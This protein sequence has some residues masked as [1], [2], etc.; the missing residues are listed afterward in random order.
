MF[1]IELW[2]HVHMGEEKKVSSIIPGN[3]SLEYY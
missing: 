1:E 2:T 3:Y